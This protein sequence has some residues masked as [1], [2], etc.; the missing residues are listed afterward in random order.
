MEVT[1]DGEALTSE[2][3]KELLKKSEGLASFGG[4]GLSSTASI[5]KASLSASRRGEDCEG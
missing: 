2:E 3:V 5:S 4:A 1:L